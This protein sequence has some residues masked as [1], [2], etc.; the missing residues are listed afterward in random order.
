M[1]NVKKLP[2]RKC[3]VCGEMK[4]KNELIRVIK[5]AENEI[6]VDTTGRKNGRGAYICNK[7]ECIELAQKNK[8][9]EKSLK[10]TISPEIYEELRRETNKNAK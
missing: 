7:K 5:N 10:C 1:G 9:I 8:G 3:V 2:L 6:M 4:V